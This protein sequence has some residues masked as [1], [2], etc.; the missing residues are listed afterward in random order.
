V[1]KETDMIE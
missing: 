1:E